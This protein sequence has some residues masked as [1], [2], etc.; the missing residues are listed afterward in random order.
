MSRFIETFPC[1]RCGACCRHTEVL[2][3]IGLPIKED[4]S[5][6]QLIETSDEEGHV[7]YGC[8]I[9]KDR[10]D[11][12]RVGFLRPDHVSEEDYIEETAEICNSLQ[13]KEG[14]PERY[15]VKLRT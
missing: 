10:P 5:C 3:A 8:A 15:R 4:G 12:C 13:L 7:I 9:Y 14:L 11:I 1:T 2:E 6:Q